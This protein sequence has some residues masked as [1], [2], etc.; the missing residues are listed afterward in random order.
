MSWLKVLAPAA[1]ALIA[2]G[3]SFTGGNAPI[4]NG[5]TTTTVYTVKPG[6]TLYAV[7]RR[8][9]LDPVAVARENGLS[10][11]S[12]LR[13]GQQIKLSISSGVQQDIERIQA[14]QQEKTSASASAAAAAPAAAKPVTAQKTETQ[15]SSN[16]SAAESSSSSAFIWPVKGRIVQP[17]S[18]LN[19][20]IDIAA[21]AGTPVKAAEDGDVVFVGNVK[22][23]GNLVI[24]R[25]TKELVTAYGRNGTITVKQG[26]KVTKGQKIADVGASDDKESRVHFEV[27]RNGKSLDPTTILPKQ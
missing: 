20:G 12:K 27:R 13:V 17:F 8:Y 7:A 4:S 9:S 26:Q 10:D 19:K 15:T 18:T 25:H 24:L 16:S 3:C 23:Y 6:D 14:H 2:A 5:P 1:V 22:G 21:S 11:P